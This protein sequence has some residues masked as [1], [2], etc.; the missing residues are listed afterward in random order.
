MFF[1]NLLSGKGKQKLQADAS[2]DMVNSFEAYQAVIQAKKAIQR[3][4]DEIHLKA[5]KEFA[6]AMHV[7]DWKE[8]NAFSIERVCAEGQY[9]TTIG[10]FIHNSTD[11]GNAPEK[12]VKQWSLQ[13]SHEE[14][15]RLAADFA[16]YIKN[17]G[18]QP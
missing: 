6:T 13:C 14:H 18:K 4:L 2:P 15:Q 5:V 9:T 11:G 12:Y 1:G 8:M 3:E 16:E 10:Y 17:K 7:I